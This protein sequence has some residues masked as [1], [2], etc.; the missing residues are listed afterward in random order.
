MLPLPFGLIS[1]ATLPGKT[2]FGLI[3]AWRFAFAMQWITGSTRSADNNAGVPGLSAGTKGRRSIN[4]SDDGEPGA[5]G[6]AL[7]E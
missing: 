2:P 5:S 1:I 4:A 6:T 3:Y 7:Q